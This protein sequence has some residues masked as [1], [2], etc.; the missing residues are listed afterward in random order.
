MSVAKKLQ[1]NFIPYQTKSVPQNPIG[2]SVE[3]KITKPPHATT[4]A[5]H[6]NMVITDPMFLYCVYVSIFKIHVKIGTRNQFE[7]FK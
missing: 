4:E 1:L 3:N 2:N 7:L 5:F 6:W